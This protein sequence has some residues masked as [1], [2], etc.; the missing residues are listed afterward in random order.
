MRR[1]DLIGM[2]TTF[3]LVALYMVFG[4]FACKRDEDKKGSKATAQNT[5]HSLSMQRNS[6]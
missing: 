6:N 1:K 5:V 3:F 4:F 2:K